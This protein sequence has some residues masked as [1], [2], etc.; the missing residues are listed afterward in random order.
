[1]KKLTTIAILSIT[2]AA[3]SFAGEKGAEKLA[4]RKSLAPAAT[5]VEHGMKCKTETRT[6]VDRSARG[7]VKISSVHTAHA[8]PS[9]ETKEVFK[10]AGKLAVRTL[11]HSCDTAAACCAG[12]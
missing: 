1:M 5:S 12:K 3:T 8:C 7:A 2:V 4:F 9:C 10:G 11:V 6:S